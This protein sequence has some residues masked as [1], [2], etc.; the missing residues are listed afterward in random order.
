MFLQPERV[1]STILQCSTDEF[2]CEDCS[3]AFQTLAGNMVE[4]DSIAE[5]IE[6]LKVN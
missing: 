6:F 5:R 3:S 2:T 4:D 1:C